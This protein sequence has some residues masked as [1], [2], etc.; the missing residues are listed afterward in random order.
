MRGLFVDPFGNNLM[1][2]TKHPWAQG[3]RIRH[4][5]VNTVLNRFCLTSNLRAECEVFGLFK[6]LLP[7][8][9]LEQEEE[10]DLQQGRK[11]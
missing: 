5:K 3:F 4:V 10:E 2:V 6:D 1:S 9:S 7:K 11:R 8:E